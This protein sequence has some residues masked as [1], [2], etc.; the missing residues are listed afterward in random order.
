MI[1]TH[2]N[3]V[4]RQ[5]SA[6][7][8]AYAENVSHRQ[9]ESLRLISELAERGPSDVVLDLGTGPGFVAHALAPD[10]RTAVGL[11]VSP[12]MARA[13]AKRAVAK[14]LEN[15][16]IA[17]G[18]NH[19]LPFAAGVFDLVVTRW[20][21]HHCWAAER[22]VAEIRRVS[23]SGGTLVI[24][25]S[26]APE[27]LDLARMMNSIE[28]LRDPSHARNLSHSGWTEL[29]DASGFEVDR[30][31]HT[32]VGLEFDDWL[33]RAATPEANAAELRRLF[34]S[35]PADLAEAFEIEPQDGHIRF[36]W[37]VSVIRGI[38]RARNAAGV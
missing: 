3:K 11:D 16:R 4:L 26:V 10:V 34:E 25:D 20:V 28:V 17:I 21:M 1:E 8:H 13:A 33:Q 9:D 37:P 6:R 19:L 35:P 18:D 32:R 5:F 30:A 2:T 12:E 38:K 31:V 22:V 23:R 7:T 27:D 14:G 29:L 24:C 36:S 15:F